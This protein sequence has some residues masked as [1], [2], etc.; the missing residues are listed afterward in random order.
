MVAQTYKFSI[1]EDQK[2]K[3]IPGYIASLKPACATG[4]LVSKKEEKTLHPQS[5]SLPHFVLPLSTKLSTFFIVKKNYVC[6]AKCMCVYHM[7][8]WC[9]WRPEDVRSPD[10]ELFKCSHVGV[11][12]DPYLL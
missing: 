12:L 4:D 3:V 5:T 8:S 1:Q 7:H 2:L 9:L 6:F 11:R 10:L